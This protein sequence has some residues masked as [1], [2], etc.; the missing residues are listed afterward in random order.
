MSRILKHKNPCHARNVMWLSLAFAASYWILEAVRDAL[1]FKIGTIGERIFFPDVASFCVRLPAMSLIVLLGVYA[2]ALG[3]KE[4]HLR[5]KNSHSAGLM[6]ILSGG[7]GLALFYW[8]LESTQNVFLSGES[9][10]FQG[11]RVPDSMVFWMRLM[12]I[13]ILLLFGVYA[14]F[15]IHQQS[16]REKALRNRQESLEREVAD[17]ANELSEAY[18]RLERAMA[19]QNSAVQELHNVNRILQT[20]RESNKAIVHATDEMTLIDEVCRI[21]VDV[22]DFP[23]VWIVYL[24]EDAENR[25]RP[26]SVAGHAYGYFDAVPLSWSDDCHDNPV[27]AAVHSGRPCVVQNTSEIDGDSPWYKEAVKR[28]YLSSVTLP[29]IQG[30]QTLG[31]MGIY[32]P[33]CDNFSPEEIEFLQGMAEDLS[34]GISTL[35][36]RIAHRQ[37]EKKKKEIEKQFIQAQKMEEVGILAGGIAHDFNNLLTAILGCADL[38]LM[39]MDEKHEMYETLHEIHRLTLNGADLVRQLLLFSRRRPT[40]FVNLELKQVIESLNRMFNRLVGEDIVFKTDVRPDLWSVRADRGMMEQVITN[41][42]VNAR[43]AMPKGGQLHITVENRTLTESDC[44]DVPEA[45][46]GRFVC[47]SVSD[48]GH[49][50]ERK[51]LRRIFEPFFTTKACGK[52]TGLGLSVVCMIVKQHQGWIR[53]R[54]RKGHGS[55]FEVYM[56]AVFEPG[57]KDIVP[58]DS[59]GAYR[60][61]G[62]HVLVVEDEEKILETMSEGLKR[63]GYK[64]SPAA[65]ASEAVHVY[66]KERG[67]FY[68]VLSDVV[69]PDGNGMELA[70]TFL[71]QNPQVGIILS[72]GYTDQKLPWSDI[73]EKGFRFLQKPYTLNCLLNTLHEI[74]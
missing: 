69:L 54:S 35:R 74:V 66:E 57:E 34:F 13:F 19:K 46:P 71:M 20:L 47:V 12:A 68:A 52:G 3:E 61:F 39:Q 6:A 4:D 24:D 51:L 7:F 70:D 65:T 9:H 25:V 10:L 16:R 27:T 45:Q 36:N 62:K 1:V 17:R 18:L 67:N 40:A 56:P 21:L 23:F 5:V 60:G 30:G 8:F 73:Q 44:R 38:A 50:I 53:V 33:E 32:R 29:L 2:Q 43:D 63:Y 22:G 41:L 59:N 26:V 42:I 31:V 11:L 28:G 72:S 55:V 14:R 58:Q 37:V 64:V 48:T 15:V 49:G